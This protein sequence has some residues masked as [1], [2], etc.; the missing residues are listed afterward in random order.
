[1]PLDRAVKKV[2]N[3]VDAGNEDIEYYKRVALALG[4]SA[5]EL[6]IDKKGGKVTPPKTDMDKLYDLNKKQ[7]IDSLL[8]LGISKKQIKA[9]KLEEDRVNAILN[10]KSIKTNKSF[11]KR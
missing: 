11:K 4:W 3:I 2:T 8:S 9:L 10:P 1:M 6:G 5:W 7:Q